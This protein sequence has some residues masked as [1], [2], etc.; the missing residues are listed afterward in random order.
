M[1]DLVVVEGL[2]Q[3]NRSLNASGRLYAKAMHAGLLEAA[4]P[5]RQDAE[6]LSMSEISGMKRAKKKTP[7]W[8]IQRKGQT[9]HEVYVAP[10]ERGVKSRTDSRRRR[11]NFA[12]L[13]MGRAYEPALERNRPRVVAIVDNWLGTVTREI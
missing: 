3:I 10:R 2:A 13:M 9:V 4:E 11:P 7:P 5:I 12:A 6:R 8:S 1:T